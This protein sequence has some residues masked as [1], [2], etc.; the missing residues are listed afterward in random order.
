[1]TSMAMVAVPKELVLIAQETVRRK[2]AEA[3]WGSP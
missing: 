1:M 2:S 3:E